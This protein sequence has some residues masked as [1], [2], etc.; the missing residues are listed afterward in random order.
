MKRR[1][2]IDEIKDGQIQGQRV[3]CMGVDIQPMLARTKKSN[4]KERKAMIQQRVPTTWPT[5]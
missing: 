4:A 3:E 5:Y 1:L 2:Q